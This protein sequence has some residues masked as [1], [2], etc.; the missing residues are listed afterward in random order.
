MHIPFLHC[1][2]LSSLC[3]PLLCLSHIHT[4]PST[5]PPYPFLSYISFSIH[6][7]PFKHPFFTRLRISI[8]FN[9]E[10]SHFT[11]LLFNAH[12][13]IT[14]YPLSTFLHSHISCLPWSSYTS[15]LH[16]LFRHHSCLHPPLAASTHITHTT[17]VLIFTILT[18]AFRP[19]VLFYVFCTI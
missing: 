9:Y 7:Y 15:L 4:K 16:Y 10:W 17:S 3:I 11:L 6:I 2:A 18:H 13:L 5:G 19:A 14:V 12:S 8:L 1:L